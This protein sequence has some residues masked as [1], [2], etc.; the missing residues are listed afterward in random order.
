MK[1]LSAALLSAS[2]LALAKFSRC[3][4][5]QT[6]CSPTAISV[7]DRAELSL[8]G[9][10]GV[11]ALKI[12][13]N[14]KEESS[15]Y[16]GS[17]SLSYELNAGKYSSAIRLLNIVK[18][19]GA[20]EIKPFSVRVSP[21]D[22]DRY[23]AFLVRV[24]AA[25]P[26]DTRFAQSV[27]LCDSLPFTKS[28][29]KSFFNFDIDEVSKLAKGG[30][31]AFSGVGDIPKILSKVLAKNSGTAKGL[32]CSLIVTESGSAHFTVYNPI[33]KSFNLEFRGHCV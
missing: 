31:I 1:L 14:A 12:A 10:G 22:A 27:W 6:Q 9:F 5:E 21:F 16:S 26:T 7:D 20:G 28:D 11:C 13:L 25:G 30:S 19:K 17:L 15:E 2:A 29:F 18:L 23:E 4:T 3:G 32:P 33:D 8:A 24:G